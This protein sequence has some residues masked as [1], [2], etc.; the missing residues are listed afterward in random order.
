[1]IV[2]TVAVVGTGLLYAVLFRPYDRLNAP[3]GDAHLAHMGVD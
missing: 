3:E 2:G 1:M